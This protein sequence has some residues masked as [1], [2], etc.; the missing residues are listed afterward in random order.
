[1]TPP[2][3]AA[4]PSAAATRT[5]D[6]A[7]PVAP[8]VAEGVPVRWLDP[9]A[10]WAASVGIGPPGSPL[11]PAL[12]ARVSL[13]FDDDALDLRLT[14]EY[15]AVV[16]PLGDAVDPAVAIAV[17]HD[18]RDLRTEAPAG[19]TYASTTAPLTRK[20]YFTAAE[21]ALVDHL[22]RTRTTQVRR[23]RTLKLAARPGESEGDF[24]AR[25]QA[26]ADDAADDAQVK[27]QQ[28]YE[29]R[30]AK[31][32]VALD[33]AADRV[34]QARAAQGTRRTSDLAAG[35][36]ALL[37]AVLG[38]K[39]RARSMAR[40]VERVITGRSRSGE[41]AQRVET[42]Q[43]R[44]GER[45]QALADLEAD[46][47][48]ELTAIDDEWRAKAADVET[49]DVPLEKSDIRVTALSLVWVPGG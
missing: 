48:A 49:V 3:P 15:E 47:A 6:D 38:G 37:G 24:A 30:I 22:Y 25:C 27:L 41:A 4:D 21:K 33:T 43:N 5:G 26:A 16:L 20:T 40:D 35:A 10:P 28:K 13:L 31:A 7:G 12:V 36:G 17:D 34:E 9:A 32:R 14:E 44:V 19:A 8:P 29:S 45:Q 39:R 2:T 42:A 11:A 23:N 1:M 18:D 46:L